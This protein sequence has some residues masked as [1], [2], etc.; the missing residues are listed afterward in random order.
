MKLKSIKIEGMHNVLEKEY[1]F[2]S[3][4]TYLH[5]PNGAGKSTALQAIQL[6]L[7]GYIPG[8]N[9][10]N[11]AIYRHA[12]NKAMSVTAII[13]AG[14]YPITISRTWTGSGSSVTGTVDVQP[15]ST[16]LDTIINELELPVFNFDEFVNMTSNKLKEW[17]IKFLPNEESEVDWAAKLNEELGEMNLIDDKLIET[18]VN[19][20]ETSVKE[21]HPGVTGVDFV[22]AVNEYLKGKLSFEKGNIDRI[23]ST[24]QSLIFHEDGDAQL[25]IEYV[26]SQISEIELLKNQLIEYNSI[27]MMNKR[28]QEI[29]DSIQTDADCLENDEKYIEAK[30]E[31]ESIESK[32]KDLNTEFTDLAAKVANARASLNGKKAM[33]PGTGICP[34]LKQE[35]EAVKAKVEEFNKEVA[36]MEQELSTATE[37]YNKVAGQKAEVEMEAQRLSKL[38]AFIEGNY[39][40]KAECQARIHPVGVIPT[41]KSIEELSAEVQELYSQISKAEANKK[42]NELIDKLTADKYKS[43]NTMQALKLWINLTG[44]NGM[45]TTMM[46]APFKKLASTITTYLQKMFND[47]SV[48]A[49]F[50]LSSKANSFSFGIIRN[51]KYIEYDLLSTGEKCLYS[52]ALMMCLTAVSSS[53][54]K[55]ILIDDLLDHLDD[56]NIEL[57]FNALSTVQ[58]I[59]FVLAGVQKCNIPEVIIEV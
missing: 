48:E 36:D 42:Y 41:S 28:N 11:A 53:E 17:F 16:T 12:R 21:S 40:S 31:Y 10:T 56:K 27:V 35:C 50:H 38:A 49:S 44:A 19:E 37:L 43:E 25:D 9:K 18:L 23:Q 30:T 1:V 34:I 47:D 5:G 20:I 45:Q 6:A 24:I 39:R 54:L 7:L 59:Q 26:R 51:E 32:W 15:E 2:D 33:S 13:D 55:L 22:Q 29:L 58:D 8:M 52:T 46:E 57:F 3:N 14:T 4:V